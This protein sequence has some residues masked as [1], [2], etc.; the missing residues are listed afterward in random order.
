[1][2][3]HGKETH[4]SDTELQNQLNAMAKS[5]RLLLILGLLFLAVVL[6]I[7]IPA[8]IAQQNGESVSSFAGVGI[9]VFFPAAIVL[10]V[11][12]SKATKRIH[13]FIRENITQAI[14]G[15][16]FDVDE[17]SCGSCI[18]EDMLKNAALTEKWD[19]CGGSDL[20]RGKYRGYDI[21][22]SNIKL[23]ISTNS[24]GGDNYQTI[25]KG[26]WVILNHGREFPGSLRI[27]D[28]RSLYN[29]RKSN[30]T[31]ENPAFNAQFQILATD[32]RMAS[33]ILTPCFMEFLASADAKE[34][35]RAFVCF[36]P[37]SICLALYKLRNSYDL[38]EPSGKNL[39]DIAL[40]REKQRA[41]LK[42]LTDILDEMMKNDYL[43]DI[44]A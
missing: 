31:T 13:A 42:Y 36:D 28:R 23:E 40:L 6:L 14:L 10:F 1:M 20:V 30:M 22:F 44:N 11:L 3:Q 19:R 32:E 21:L 18:S 15:E 12:Y 34:R 25:F 39:R 7:G 33:R 17:Y 38:F 41:E 26:P 2:N 4:L 27:R 8:A 43:F 35:N 29:T 37:D 5:A 24:D 16:I 9:L